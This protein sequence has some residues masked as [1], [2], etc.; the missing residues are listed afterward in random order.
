MNKVVV[1]YETCRSVSV[2]A[3]F[4]IIFYMDV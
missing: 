1:F 4:N 2:S 3:F